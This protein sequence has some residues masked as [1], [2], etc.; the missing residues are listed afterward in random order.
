M[1]TGTSLSAAALAELRSIVRGT[2]RA[3]A[4]TREAYAT[5][6]SIYHIRPAAVVEPLDREDLLTA[7]QWCYRNGHPIVPR[8]GGTSL[9]GQC[10]NTGV[11]I[12]TSRHLNRIIAVNPD[13]RWV[14]VEPGLIRDELNRALAAHVLHFAPDPA[15]T[16]RATIGGMISNNS[17]GMRSIKY[18]MTIDHL[19]QVE[20][21]LADGEVITLGQESDPALNRS[22]RSQSIQAELTALMERH[23]TEI[24]ERF[25]KVGRRAGGYPLDAF[26]GPRPWN[27]AKLI[28]GSEGTLG[29]IVSARL[30]LEP[31]PA[32]QGLCL[33]HF[34]SMDT[35]LRSVQGIVER[36]ASAVELLDGVILRQ[37]REHPLT[38]QTCAMIEAEPEAILVIECRTDN[39]QTLEQQLASIH[40]HLHGGEKAY[41]VR[42]MQTEADIAAV[43]LMRESALGLMTTVTGTRKPIPYIEDAAVPLEVLPDYVADVQQVCAGYNQPVSLFA[44]AGAGLLHIRPLHDL[45]SPQDRDQLKAIQDRAFELVVQYGGSWSGEHGDGIVR[46]AYNQQFFGTTLFNAFREVK[47]LFD[48]DHRMN[49]GKII[50]TPDRMDHLRVDAGRTPLP[51]ETA[52]RWQV[53]GGWLR[54]TEQCTG[55]GACRKLNSGVMCPSY[56]ALRDEL[57]STRGRA[58]IL[59]AALSG[60][61]PSD[62]WQSDAV[63]DALDLC[64]S[65]KGCYSECPNRVDV[66]KMKSEWLHQYHKK[67]TRPQRHQLFA[68]LSIW[69]R[70]LSGPQAGSI[71]WLLQRPFIKRHLQPRFGL[72]GERTLPSFTSQRFTTWFRRHRRRA[73]I[74]AGR[75]VMLFTDLYTEFHEPQIGQAAV[76]TLEAL[77]YAVSITPV[78]DSQRAALSLGLLDQAKRRGGRVLEQL[79]SAA[80]QGHPIVV[81]EPSCATALRQDLLDLV[82]DADLARNISAHTFFWDEFLWSEFSGGHISWPE[83]TRA[84]NAGFL[85]LHCHQ[86]ALDNGHSTSALLRSLPEA[87]IQMSQAGCCGMAG[88]FG[89]EREHYQLSVQIA[90][91]RL[92]PALKEVPTTTVIIAPG[93]SCRHQIQDLTGR[94]ALHSAEF[95]TASLPP[96]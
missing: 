60:E 26:T 42:R 51:V 17:A 50:D 47:H 13:E 71:N 77:G 88:A 72:A 8:G 81:L 11:V 12:D 73:P 38:R 76:R 92:L 10:V 83:G 5:D 67:H 54:A 15:T 23:Q 44:H 85:H 21:A 90:E 25:P 61:L 41:A 63:R 69:G 9:V 80:D 65:C 37:A 87:D 27:L 93:F 53:E 58:N 28:A 14:D 52:F 24:L 64:L 35:C 46:A 56:M 96:K 45:R 19:L 74:Q 2:V 68:N 86:H 36:G 32:F 75:P 84:A 78:L 89:Y 82:D 70:C 31:V 94:S 40:E 79:R 66:G 59:R 1:D 57:H 29:M 95:L 55:I 62:A 6:A 43:W 30:H 49:P 18:G 20:L 48:P 33:A 4:V 7:I 16:S 34:T 39:E 91:D 3:D 22:P